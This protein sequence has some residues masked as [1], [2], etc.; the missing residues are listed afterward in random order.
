MTNTTNGSKYIVNN[1]DAVGMK[2]LSSGILVLID[3]SGSGEVEIARTTNPLAVTSF[4]IQMYTWTGGVLPNGI[5]TDSDFLWEIVH[6]YAGTEAGVLNG[7]LTHT[8]LKRNLALSPGEKF[9]IPL[10]GQGFGYTFGI[11]YTLASTGVVTAEDELLTSFKYQTNESIIAD[12]NWSHNTSS[13]RYFLAGSSIHSWR[14]GGAGTVQ[15]LFS[16]R[17]TVNNTLEIWSETYNDLVATSLVNPNGSDIYLHYGINGNTNYSY[18]PNITKQTIGQGTQPDVNFVPTVANQ[19][20]TVT[21][22]E[23][24]NFQ[25][26]TSDNVVNQFVESDAPSWITINQN[27]GILSGTAPAYAGTSADTIVVNCKAGNAIGGSV[28][29]TVTV[30]VAQAAA[31]YTNTQSLV[32][33]SSSGYLQGNPSNVTALKRASNGSGASDAWTINMWVKLANDSSTQQL[34]Y[35]GGDSASKGAISITQQNTNNIVFVYGKSVN[36]IA[37]FSINQVT[38][39]AWTMLTFTYSGASTGVYGPSLGNYFDAFDTYINGVA[40]STQPAQIGN[41]Y[42]NDLPGDLFRIGRGLTADYAGVL[43]INQVAIYDSENFYL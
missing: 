1:G 7:V 14:Q 41:G 5:I 2:F 28:N 38:P 37:E 27:S 19:T 13:T 17:Y 3:Y 43:S 24:L 23:V 10:E 9:M 33:T 34:F 22:A 35:Y 15:G 40:V 6:D 8:V 21:E 42:S 26:I 11:D 32:L 12:N 20:V 31:T 39:G 25:I 30:T 36:L 29:F 18:L 16:L 4:N